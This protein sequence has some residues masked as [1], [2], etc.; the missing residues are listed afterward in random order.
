MLLTNQ[1]RLKLAIGSIISVGPRP[2]ISENITNL[3]LLFPSLSV[4]HKD[5]IA[6]KRKIDVN[7]VTLNI[8][9]KM[10]ADINR[11][12]NKTKSSIIKLMP[13]C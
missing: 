10:A 8:K 2:Q 12:L 4:S 5:G 11:K 6:K 1:I 9:E 7:K 3:M 13:F